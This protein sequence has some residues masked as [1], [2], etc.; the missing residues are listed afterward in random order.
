MPC[1]SQSE[2]P[3]SVQP[4]EILSR[5]QQKLI[6]LRAYPAGANLP[7]LL[8]LGCLGVRYKTKSDS[9]SGGGGLAVG[10]WRRRARK[11]RQKA[12]ERRSPDFSSHPISRSA[13]PT[14]TSFFAVRVFRSPIPFTSTPRQAQ[15]SIVMSL[16][17][18]ASL[19]TF[20]SVSADDERPVRPRPRR[21]SASSSYA[22]SLRARKLSFNPLPEAWDPAFARHDDIPN[23]AV[24]AFEVP[25]WKRICM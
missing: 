10:E 24:G 5:H 16:N 9:G 19:E 6:R 4:R 18:V 23:P 13:P 12:S 8:L 11:A 20:L 7:Q 2:A 14:R 25:Q 15:P 1:L 21:D 17:R 22:A 3:N